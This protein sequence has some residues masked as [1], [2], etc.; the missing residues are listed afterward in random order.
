MAPNIIKG[1]SHTDQRGTISFVNDF[2]MGQVK[3]FYV[4]DHPNTEVIRG[5]RG[6]KIEQRW[7]HVA[8]GVFTID[9][10]KIDDFD[11]PSVDLPVTQFKLFA[12]DT[13]I[14]HVP[15]GYA[16]SIQALA[17]NSKVIVFADYGVE[18]AP[19]DDFLYPV[20]YFLNKI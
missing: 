20:N 4:I 2:D 18:N 14:L 9:L 13:E 19:L 5:W 16:S 3:R 15:A 17:A 10:V 7:F 11:S 8:K 6:H 1:G 12:K